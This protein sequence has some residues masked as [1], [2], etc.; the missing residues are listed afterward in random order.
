MTAL[1]GAVLGYYG[2]ACGDTWASEVGVLAPG[3][4]LLVT[5]GQPVPKGAYR[6]ASTPARLE[7]YL[8]ASWHWHCAIVLLLLM[9]H[10]HYCTMAQTHDIAVM[11]PSCEHTF[12]CCAFTGTNGGVSS[13]GLAF[14]AAGGLTMGLTGLLFAMCGASS[15]QVCISLSLAVAG[16]AVCN[17]SSL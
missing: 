14:S 7:V 8:H 10:S 9:G 5:T 6:V 1:Q 3:K 2:C 15:F 13:L 12:I 16:I 4:P 11:L 17:H